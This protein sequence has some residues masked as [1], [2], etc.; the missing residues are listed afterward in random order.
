[1]SSSRAVTE[2]TE[3]CWFD[4]ILKSVLTNFTANFLSKILSNQVRWKTNYLNLLTNFTAL[5]QKQNK[6][7]PQLNQSGPFEALET[8]LSLRFTLC[9]DPKPL[10]FWECLELCV[11]AIFWTTALISDL[12]CSSLKSDLNCA[13]GSG[14][15]GGP[16]HWPAHQ[17]EVPGEGGGGEGPDLRPSLPADGDRGQDLLPWGDEERDIR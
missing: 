11:Y 14:D 8:T 6:M 17:G 1:M 13:G 3:E 2:Q 9:L 5:K 4:K 15:S 10:F 7:S 12:E 16:T